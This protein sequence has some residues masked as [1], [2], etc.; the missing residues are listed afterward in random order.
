[1][2]TPAYSIQALCPYFSQATALG[3]SCPIFRER[4]QYGLTWVYVCLRSA[5]FSRYPQRTLTGYWEK[6]L[7]G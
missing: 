7:S 5:G 6:I 4:N 1:M 2:L 3:R